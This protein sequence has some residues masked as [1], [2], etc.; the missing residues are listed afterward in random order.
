MNGT[1]RYR[2]RGADNDSHTAFVTDRSI[3]FEIGE[4]LYRSSYAPPFDEL[5]WIEAGDPK[6]AR[7]MVGKSSSKSS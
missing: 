1:G 3:S 7:P 2:T 6:P 5:P 4:R